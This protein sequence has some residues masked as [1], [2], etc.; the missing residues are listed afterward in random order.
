MNI[1]N[2]V[3]RPLNIGSSA[4]R[5][6]CIQNNWF[7]AGTNEQYDKLFWAERHKASI[8]ELA[9]IVW[10]CSEDVPLLDIQ[11]D[12]VRAR[13]ERD[14]QLMDWKLLVA[15]KI[16]RSFD[17]KLL[18]DPNDVDLYIEVNTPHIIEAV[19]RGNSDWDDDLDII[20]SQVL[21]CHR[22]PRDLAYEE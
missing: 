15:E 4:L 12:L 22:G 19:R 8:A 20:Q 3:T 7:T 13:V 6:L 11:T 5:S 21:P 16:R 17:T 18:C 10:T 9:L 1:Q 14:Q 2:D